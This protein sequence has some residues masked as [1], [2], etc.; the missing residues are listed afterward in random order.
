MNLFFFLAFGTWPWILLFG[1]FYL[2]IIIVKGR[3]R[4][5]ADD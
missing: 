2:E 5:V 3:G 1:V 4:R